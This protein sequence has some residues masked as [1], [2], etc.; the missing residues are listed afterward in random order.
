MAAHAMIRE[1]VSRQ[2]PYGSWS[3]ADRNY[4]ARMHN[5]SVAVTALL[6]FPSVFLGRDYLCPLRYEPER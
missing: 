4:N 3:R 1:L 6:E 2:N 5:A